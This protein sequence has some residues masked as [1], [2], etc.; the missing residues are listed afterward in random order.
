MV[1]SQDP[2]NPQ[3]KREWHEPEKYY[4][5]DSKG[6]ILRDAEGKPVP[7]KLP[8]WRSILIQGTIDFLVLVVLL[9]RYTKAWTRAFQESGGEEAVK[10]GSGVGFSTAP[11]G[12]KAMASLLRKLCAENPS[13]LVRSSDVTGM[14]WSVGAS[15]LIHTYRVW[16]DSPWGT[17][18]MGLR[19]LRRI[20]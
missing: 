10:F 18:A 11:E 9:R 13:S 6:A 4:A 3:I 14:D 2:V 12:K 19:V 20:Y 8:R 16:I 17:H 15:G 7:R 5:T 1:L